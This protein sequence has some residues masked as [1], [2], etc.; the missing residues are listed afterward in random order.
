[1]RELTKPFGWCY[2]F[3][4]FLLWRSHR[5]SVNVSTRVTIAKGNEQ[6]DVETFQRIAPMFAFQMDRLRR[7][8]AGKDITGV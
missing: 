5:F 8:T 2:F 3:L 4:L 7:V 1:M 6:K